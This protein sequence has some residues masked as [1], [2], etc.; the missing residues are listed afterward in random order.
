MATDYT[1]IRVDRVGHVAEVVL[2]NAAKMN[3]MAP[4]FFDEIRSV[5]DALDAD[6]EVRAIVLWSEG[7]HF[8]AG[9]DLMAAAG[10]IVGGDDP[11]ALLEVI[12][13]WQESFSAVATC[14]KPVIAAVQG[15]CIGGGVDL[16]TACDIRVCTEQ[17]AFSI[18]ETKIAMVADLGTLQRLT[19]IVGKGIAR[20]MAFT[21]AQLPADRAL[22]SGLVNQVYASQE[23]MLE[24]ARALAAEIAANSP[25]AVQGAKV[26]LNYSDEHTTQEGL[27]FVA[28][29]NSTRL[30]S[31]DLT[32][33]LTAFMEKRTPTFTGE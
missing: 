8:T 31:N 3:A 11:A 17:A 33:A 2:D 6:D 18:D 10:S 23:A 20:E 9:L 16:T 7:R 30:R 28:D 13:V 12:R 27:D 24:G 21:G 1:A 14:R 5:F 26:V 32:E 15:R 25:L 22:Q 19:A 4:V 29:W